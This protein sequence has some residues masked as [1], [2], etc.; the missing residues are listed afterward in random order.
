LLFVFALDLGFANMQ[1]TKR[2]GAIDTQVVFPRDVLD[3]RVN[4][5]EWKNGTGAH[6]YKPVAV[7]ATQ[8]SVLVGEPL[9]STN[10]TKMNVASPIPALS[11]LNGLR[12]PLEVERECWEIFNDMETSLQ[13]L[14]PEEAAFQIRENIFRHI[15]FAGFA[16]SVYDATNKL[17]S[18]YYS[19]THGGLITVKATGSVKV[20][21]YVCIDIPFDERWMP[22]TLKA[23]PSSAS[24]VLFRDTRNPD[25]KKTL[26]VSA[27][28]D[29]NHWHTCHVFGTLIGQCV[30]GTTSKCGDIEIVLGGA[31]CN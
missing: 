27:V 19:A 18:N 6:L 15:Q 12:I 22:E 3:Y 2:A 31:V 20:G 7:T 23:P 29:A 1:P 17:Q 14:Q 24:T 11:S 25:G 16:I 10:D 28:T 5:T 21:D 30:R 4:I 8:L 13:P 9:Y 26:L